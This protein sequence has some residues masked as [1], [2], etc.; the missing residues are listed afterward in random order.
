MQKP[1]LLFNCQFSLR[2][3]PLVTVIIQSFLT[4]QAPSHKSRSEVALDF[5]TRRG[6]VAIDL[7]GTPSIGMSS[8]HIPLHVGNVV[9]LGNIT[10]FLHVW[11]FVLRHGRKKVINDL[12]RYKGVPEV[13]LCDVWLFQGLAFGFVCTTDCIDDLPCRR[14]L[15]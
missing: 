4:S 1:H 5:K 10:V 15:P 13:K 9:E 2:V 7:L 11:A 14:R 8:A 6:L 3:S 12:I